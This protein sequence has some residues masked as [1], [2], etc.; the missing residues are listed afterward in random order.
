MTAFND[1]NQLQ[2]NHLIVINLLFAKTAILPIMQQKKGT[3]W[4]LSAKIIEIRL[5]SNELF[6]QLLS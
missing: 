4:K 5:F 3:G 2:I 6:L 1:R